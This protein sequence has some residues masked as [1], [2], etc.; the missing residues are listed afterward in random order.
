MLNMNTVIGFLIAFFTIGV[1]GQTTEAVLIKKIEGLSHPESVVIDRSSNILYVSNIGEQETRDGFISKVS[2]N[3]DILEK[4]WIPG[5]KDP[6]GLLI[7]NEELYVT[8]VT[9]FVIMSLADEKIMEIIE[10]KEAVSLNDIAAGENGELY[11]SDHKKSSV[12]RR[13]PS[14]EITEW[15]HTEELEFPNGLWVDG[16]Y[17]YIAAWGKEKNGNLLRVDLSSKEI[18]NITHT[19]IGNLDGIQPIGNEEFY[20][21]DWATGKI[22]RMG[23][24]GNYST[25]FTAEKSTGDFLY[26]QEEE[27]LILP[28]NHQNALWWYRLEKKDQ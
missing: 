22:Y 17:L 19:G 13:D 2:S 7:N 21:S 4:E 24:D 27:Q 9:E 16:N 26:L 6:K 8:D 14:G 5:L 12:F 15:L 23:A 1:Y 11:I 3:G 20:V 25:I 10:V 28:M 18:E